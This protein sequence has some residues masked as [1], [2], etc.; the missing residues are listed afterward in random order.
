MAEAGEATLT[1]GFAGP[2]CCASLSAKSCAPCGMPRHWRRPMPSLKRWSPA[3]EKTRRNSRVGSKPRCPKASPCSSCRKNT[4]GACARLIRSNDP[5]SR[6]S[7]AG[8]RR[9][10]S[11]RTRRR[12]NPRLSHPRRNRRDLDRLPATLCQLEVRRCGLNPQLKVQTSGCVIAF[13]VAQSNG[14]IHVIDH[15]LLPK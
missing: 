14:V 15:V 7:N 6:N 2:R 3:I 8:P 12:S 5:S 11:S 13:D 9:Y 4:G 1:L 10:A